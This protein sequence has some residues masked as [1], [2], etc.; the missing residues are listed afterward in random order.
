MNIM[1]PDLYTQSITCVHE[2]GYTDEITFDFEPNN[3]IARPVTKCNKCDGVSNGFIK[4]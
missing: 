3:E 4:N 1:E 2:W